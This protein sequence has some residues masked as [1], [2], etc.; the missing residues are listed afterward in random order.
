MEDRI[1]DADGCCHSQALDDLALIAAIDGEAS[2]EVVAHLR[3]CGYCAARA[4]DFAQLQGL[5]RKQFFR[6]FCPSTD[7]LVLHYQGQLPEARRAEIDA[8]LREC[9]HCLRELRLLK[10]VA[11]EALSGRAPPGQLA[12]PGWAE[13]PPGAMAEAGDLP[14]S[15]V[16]T[17]PSP[18]VHGA[19]RA[20]RYTDQYAF[21]ADNLQITI[22]IHR[23]VGQSE[24]RVLVG[25]LSLGKDLPSAGC[26][27]SAYRA[28]DHWLV[29]TAELD[30]LGS[31]VLA[32]LLAGPYRLLVH[33]PEREVVI[34]AISV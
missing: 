1:Q 33:L 5:L 20:A 4:Q 25:V 12:A 27:V 14:A 31:F 21:Q 32:D 3:T 10:Q 34:E 6:M 30:E 26:Y 24:R 16:A 8:H 28:P 23:V 7:D 15:Q 2:S 11:S 17:A 9:S 18:E 19:P 22:D 29:S 13:A